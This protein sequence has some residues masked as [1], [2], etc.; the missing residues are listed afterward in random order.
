MCRSSRIR[1]VGRF[2]IFEKRKL[3]APWKQFFDRNDFSI[4]TDKMVASGRVIDLPVAGEGNES[5]LRPAT[6]WPLITLPDW[7]DSLEKLRK[8]RP[9][10]T[11]GI[12]KIPRM[13]R[14]L[15]LLIRLIMLIVTMVS[16][17]FSPNDQDQ[18]E[19]FQQL[20]LSSY[21]LSSWWLYISTKNE[22]G[23]RNKKKK[24]IRLPVYGD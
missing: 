7:L 8:T 2:F 17:F 22:N 18:D 13:L 9:I 24:W 19:S 6:L 4:L 16:C 5:G 20:C 11:F 3:A 10:P 15:V 23:R 12:V 1:F 21:Y 14:H